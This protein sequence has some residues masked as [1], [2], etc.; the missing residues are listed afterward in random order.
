MGIYTN[1][2]LYGATS[3][4]T[5]VE[6]FQGEHF[7]YHELGILAANEMAINHNSL[8]KAIGLQEL[9]AFEQTGDTDVFYEAVNVSGI[10][11]KIKAFFKKIIEKIHKLFHTFIAK[12]GSWFG[13]NANFVKKYEKEVVK[14]WT[15]VKNDWGFKG[16][17]YSINYD[18]ADIEERLKVEIVDASAGLKECI[19]NL[20]LSVIL[21]TANI[22]TN[23]NDDIKAVREKMDDIKDA[24]RKRIIDNRSPL[25]AFKV[26][27]NNVG[28]G[29]DSSEFTEELFKMWRSGE[30]AKEE[31]T[32]SDVTDSYGGSISS[33]MSFVKDFDKIK[34]K[35][36]T[37]ERKLTKAVDK[38]ISEIDKKQNDIVKANRDEK[39][40]DTKNANERIVQGASILQSIYGAI[41]DLNTQFFG[42][43][44]QA[45]KDACAQA[46]EIMV[47][48]VGQ[49]KKI[50]EESADVTSEY[51]GF[52]ANV[53]L[54]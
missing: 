7:N 38:I 15:N 34:T 12:M 2:A 30:D 45:T 17:K 31:L 41:G 47:K 18:K 23:S 10:V 9:A 3:D 42:S 32:K 54:V 49:S 5:S 19:E 48:I 43:H 21:K 6:P 50:T 25:F 20:D 39:D 52:L 1:G 11:E 28:A 37:S 46:K 33:M 16:Y 8:M 27:V 4:Y 13:N 51:G 35:L 44:L 29:L 53:E 22:S 36:E 26:H 14:G 40:N 24:M